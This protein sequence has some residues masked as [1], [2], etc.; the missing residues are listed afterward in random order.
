MAKLEFTPNAL[1]TIGVELEL[2]IVNGETYQLESG[3]SRMIERLE[4]DVATAV[5]HELMQCC[6]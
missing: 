5:K 6:V 1:P 4:A 2:G 3:C